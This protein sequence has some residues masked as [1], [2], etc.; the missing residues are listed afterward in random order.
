MAMQVL[1]ETRDLVIRVKDMT[2][3]CVCRK[4]KGFGELLI[5]TYIS[6]F[7]PMESRIYHP[8]YMRRCDVCQG[9]RYWK[10]IH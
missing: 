6:P 4:C 10:V 3:M 7:R 5:P 1:V 8:S 9:D 2:D